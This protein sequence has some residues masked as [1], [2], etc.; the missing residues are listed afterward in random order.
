MQLRGGCS[1]WSSICANR[2]VSL[3]VPPRQIILR[4]RVVFTGVCCVAVLWPT[5]T[6]KLTDP[7]FEL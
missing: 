5:G 1:P 3:M 6:D 7:L 4:R 2:H